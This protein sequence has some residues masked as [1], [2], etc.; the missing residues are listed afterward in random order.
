MRKVEESMS[1]ETA[2]PQHH[3][4]LLVTLSHPILIL[5]LYFSCTFYVVREESNV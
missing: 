3:L 1:G 2:G 4:H 5:F